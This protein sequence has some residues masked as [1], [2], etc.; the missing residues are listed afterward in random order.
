M[1]K[2]RSRQVEA[3]R[4]TKAD[5]KL[6]E[7]PFVALQRIVQIAEKAGANREDI[8]RARTWPLHWAAAVI[9]AQQLEPLAEIGWKVAN[10]RVKEDTS[11]RNERDVRI[12]HTAVQLLLDGASARGLASKIKSHLK[13]EISVRHINRILND[14]MP[15]ILNM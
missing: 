1:S 3:L 2:V 8:V 15:K 7:G 5:E 6:I 14:G 12:L 10:S 4:P 13:L 9:R 11:A